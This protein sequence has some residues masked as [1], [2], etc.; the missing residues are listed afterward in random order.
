[1]AALIIFQLKAH[2]IVVEFSH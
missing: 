1:M 2:I